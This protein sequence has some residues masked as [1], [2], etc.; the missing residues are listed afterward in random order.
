VPLVAR[1]PSA[2]AVA[3]GLLCGGRRVDCRRELLAAGAAPRAESRAGAPGAA[4]AGAPVIKWGAGLEGRKMGLRYLLVIAVVVGLCVLSP[5]KP[6][7]GL[8][9]YYWFAMMRPD[10]LA[11]AGPNR[12][13]FLLAVVTLFSNTPAILRN[14]PTAVLNPILRKLVLLLLL[15]T[16]SVIT[17]VDPSLCMERYQLFLRVFLM[18]FVI[19]LILV[20][21]EQLRW[22]FVVLSGSLGLLGSKY[23]LFGV[24]MGGASFQVGYGGLLSDNN[25]MALAFAMAVPMCWYARHLLPWKSARVAFIAMSILNTAAVIFTHSRGGILAV[26]SALLLIAISEKRKLFALAL[27]GIGAL[28]VSYLVWNSLSSRLETLKN[29]M[30]EDSARSRIILATY[31]AP[32]MWLDYPFFGVGF[33]ETNQQRLVFKYVPP[34]YAAAYAGKVL[35]NNWLQILVD[36]GIFAFLVY[37]WLLFG[38]GL[39]TWI[40]AKRIAA[41]ESME[42][43]A[44]P[45][46]ISVSLGTF[47][48]GATFLSRTTF[49]LFYVLLC[50][51]A[52]WMEIRKTGLQPAPAV[53]PPG[54]EASAGQLSAP[55]SETAGRGEREPGERHRRRPGRRISVGQSTPLFP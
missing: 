21:Q 8:Y 54:S 41:G 44:I 4:A 42:K 46:A 28:G 22:F 30:E 35:H 19:P 38:T 11:W 33:T 12:Y 49:D 5:I 7:L 31:A 39:K 37:M 16:I 23:G 36:S 52:A 40:A 6:V 10:I 26:G 43:A 53:P 17:A 27:L 51:A 20:T 24:R 9:G 45:F 48:V 32:R 14:L 34:E 18:A 50:T 29:P 25:T 3:R 15:I 13:S 47:L 2:S 1:M 55:A